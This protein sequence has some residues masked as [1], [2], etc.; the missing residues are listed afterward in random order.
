MDGCRSGGGKVFGRF[1]EPPTRSWTGREEAE[2]SATATS[3]EQSA[4]AARRGPE[5]G[6]P[7]TAGQGMTCGELA[8]WLGSPNRGVV[9]A[10]PAQRR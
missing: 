9:P 2:R 6:R 10:A 3:P 4:R 7:G 8:A 1:K 5:R